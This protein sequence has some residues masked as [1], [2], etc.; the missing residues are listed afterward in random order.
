MTAKKT[1]FVGIVALTAFAASLVMADLTDEPFLD[2]PEAMSWPMLPG[3]SLNQLAKLFYPKNKAMQKRFVTKTLELSHEIS[4]NLDPDAVFKQPARLIVPDLKALSQSAA[5]FKA[6]R[7]STAKFPKLHMSY[8]IADAEKFL[9]TPEMQADFDDLT[10]RNVSLKDELKRLND[11]LVKL[12]QTMVEMLE[13][14]RNTLGRAENKPKVE[15]KLAP[16]QAPIPAA[17]KPEVALQ[18]SPVEKNPA[19]KQALTKPPAQ[20]SAPLKQPE[21]KE[22]PVQPIRPATAKPVEAVKPAPAEPTEPQDKFS[23]AVVPVPAQ[24]AK[25]EAAAPAAP[26]VSAPVAPQPTPVPAPVPVE[27]AAVPVAPRPPAP[28]AEASLLDSEML[29][30]AI[31]LGAIVLGLIG[32]FFAWRWIRKQI[33]SKLRKATNDQLDGLH[34]NKFNPN[35]LSTFHSSKPGAVD[36]ADLSMLYIEEFESVVEEARIFMSMDRAKEAISIL[37]QHIQ[38]QPKTSIHPW[39]Y[40]MEV[41]RDLDMRDEFVDLAKRFHEHFNVIA[42]QWHSDT[43]IGMV[44][45]ESL[46]EFPHIISQLQEIWQTP[47][48]KPYLE[49]LIADN[50]DGERSGFS[51]EVIKEIMMLMA[52]L[53]MRDKQLTLD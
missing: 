14:A 21:T 10:K 41:Y 24:A 44:I 42:P 39:I 20:E 16:T 36:N 5:G 28:V 4:P 1:Y 48:A 43:Q 50:R 29:G 15:A 12:Q 30:I 23:S 27:Q 17:S 31:Q 25:P 40:L 52:M 37:T 11:K 47:K 18:K 9:V 53:D 6:S 8:Q 26:A 7:R 46:E 2:T 13:K 32:A 45:A 38:E 19:D 22:P 35:D 33:A 49:S 34:K 51:F 3:E